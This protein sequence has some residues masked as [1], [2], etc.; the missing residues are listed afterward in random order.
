[1]GEEAQKYGATPE[2]LPV[3]LDAVEGAENLNLMGLM[4]IP[5]W[6][7]DA[8]ET[9]KHFVRLRKLRDQHG[10]TDRLPCLS[11]GMSHDFEVAVEE[12]ATHVRVGTAI[13]GVRPAK[14]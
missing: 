8:E 5:P 12:G 4:T 3:L 9:R 11:M 1:V 10:G 13:F 2:E 7:L 6:D 14:R